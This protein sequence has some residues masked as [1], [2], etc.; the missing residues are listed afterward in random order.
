L[1]RV[2][3]SAVKSLWKWGNSMDAATRRSTTLSKTSDTNRCLDLPVSADP[4]SPVRRHGDPEHR[5]RCRGN[6]RTR[7]Q[8]E[9]IP[10]SRAQKP[11]SAGVTPPSGGSTDTAPARAVRLT[12]SSISD[13]ATRRDTLVASIG[14]DTCR[15]SLANRG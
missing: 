3:P 11:E 14:H 7:S 1:L 15:G 2:T 5:L 6:D 8:A 9:E 10:C 13:P 12:S 4:R